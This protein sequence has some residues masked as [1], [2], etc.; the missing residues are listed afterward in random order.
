[1]LETDDAT[2]TAG[3]VEER[4][5]YTPYG[6][7]IVIKGDAGS[8]QLGNVL[9]TSSVGNPFAHQGLPFDQAKRSYQN[10]RR[11]RTSS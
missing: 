4:Y 6:E 3:R 5:A 11:F 8:G 9:V 10:R 7:F 1:M 2:G